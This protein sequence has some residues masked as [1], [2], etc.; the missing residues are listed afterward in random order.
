MWTLALIPVSG[1]LNRVRGGF[2]PTGHTQVARAIF[3]V[4]MGVML[5]LGQHDWRLLT[6]IPV[7][8]VGEFAPN[9]DYLGMTSVWQFLE[10]TSVG[11][12]N[13]FLPALLM[14]WL[15]YHFAAVALVAA[16]ALKGVCYLVAK[17][18]PSKI[19][20]FQQGAEMAELLFGLVLG[21]GVVL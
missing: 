3:A 1:L 20:N 19:T 17:F 21:V 11:I 10:A 18:I 6:T 15:G 13:V 5:A 8:F 16:G 4:G 12:A 7:W 14:G 9:G 2:L